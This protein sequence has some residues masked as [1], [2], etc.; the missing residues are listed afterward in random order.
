MRKRYK[1][2]IVVCVFVFAYFVPFEKLR[3]Q[4]AIPESFY[5]CLLSLL[6]ALSLLTMI[7]ITSL[8]MTYDKEVF[9]NLK[10]VTGVSTIA[11]MAF[12]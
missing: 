12:G 8:L 4:K 2:P 7:A 11:G 6:P 9:Y 5:I 1:F 3:A 10:L